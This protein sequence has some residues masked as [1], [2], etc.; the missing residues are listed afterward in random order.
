MTCNISWPKFQIITSFSSDVVRALEV[1]ADNSIASPTLPSPSH[2]PHLLVNRP[3]F[4]L[5]AS[6]LPTPSRFNRP[7]LFPLPFWSRGTVL[8]E[9]FCSPEN[10]MWVLGISGNK[11]SP[12]HGIN[13]GSFYPNLVNQTV[14]R[15]PAP[16]I[17][18][19]SNNAKKLFGPGPLS[20]TRRLSKSVLYTQ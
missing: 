8:E 15:R 16:S 1:G 11:T 19:L 20:Y 12:V 13:W 2:C 10:H 14:R 17:H 18:E 7:N 5:F 6:P 3:F 4:L 9:I